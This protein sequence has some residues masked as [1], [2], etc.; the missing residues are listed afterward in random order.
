MLKNFWDGRH[1]WPAMYGT[2]GWILGLSLIV[3]GAGSAKAQEIQIPGLPGLAGGDS[4]LVP[5]EGPGGLNEEN[6]FELSAS[7]QLAN[8]TRRGR[9]QVSATLFKEWHLYSVTQQKGGP[10]PTTFKI[11]NPAGVEISGPI[12]PDKPAHV[13]SAA[14]F[15]GIKIEE[16]AD[17]VVWTAPFTL[18][19]GVSLEG[20]TLQVQVRGLACRTGGACIPVRETLTAAQAGTYEE[21]AAPTEFRNKGSVVAW[22][23]EITPS[24]VAPGG[25]AQLRI[26]AIPDA[27]FH[28]YA[29]VTS[30]Q[31]NATNFLVTAPGGVEAS[32]PQTSA[33][34]VVKPGP[35]GE[36]EVRY[37]EGVV[38]WV[39]PLKVANNV[40]AGDYPISG[41]V[42]YQA[43]TDTSCR[44]PKGLQFSGTLK[45]GSQLTDANAPLVF[46]TVRHPEVLDAIT[47]SSWLKNSP[48]VDQQGKLDDAKNGSTP[49]ALP[50]NQP[51]AH[52]FVVILGMALIGGL[53]LNLMPCVLPVVGLKLMAL[54][55]TAGEDHRKVFSHNM[56]YSLGLLT[57]FWILAAI[58]IFVRVAYAK[59]FSWG[60]QFTFFEFRLGLILLVF[61]MALSFLGIWEIPL[62]GFASG[63]AS[64]Q[65]QK[66]EGPAGAFFKGIFTTLL[67]TPCSG[68]LLGVVFGSTLA[69]PA[70]AIFLVFSTVGLGMALPYILIGLMPKLVFWLPKPGA[71]METFKQLMAF[72]L[73]GT[74]AFLFSG[75]SEQHKVP[76]FVTLIAAWF[77]CWMIGRVPQWDTLQR[78]LTAWTGGLVTASVIG[79]GAF[80]YLGAQEEKFVWEPYSETRLAELQQ[81]GQTVMVD[82]TAD[83]CV[84]CIINY[85]V[86]LNTSTTASVINELG[87]VAMIADWSDHNDEVGEKLNELQSN[88]IPVLAIYPGRAP[89]KP[90][91][92]RDIVT[93]SQ[94]VDALRQ[95]GASVGDAVAKK[96]SGAGVV[97]KAHP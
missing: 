92:L 14:E 24:T 31:A 42:G 76:V 17:N 45:V 34:V 10:T 88:S 64:Q 18:P 71:W 15:P 97:A 72:V 66:K 59:S 30:D 94:V 33:E 44:Q 2:M 8:G 22:R 3:L 95:A 26:T 43:C 36:A 13:T 55:D 68:P 70:P 69:L 27:T 47:A 79:Y 4:F 48:S 87:A 80:N 86:A 39:I 9:L 83:W 82:F 78:R 11:L 96:G 52:S 7:F 67:A 49:A 19:E 20:L 60:Q 58:A 73:L 75:F 46:A 28:V 61:V 51:A 16:H 93:Q 1:R 12:V 38:T 65:L 54:V 91:V 63:K 74:V 25:E 62:P 81:A 50:T 57:V 90:I 23:G 84:N 29:A 41:M 37:H 85:K 6:P 89:D 32:A 5:G 21:P 77:A 40:G 53:I 56:W 35:P